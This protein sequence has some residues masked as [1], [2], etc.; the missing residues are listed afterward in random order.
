MIRWS[1]CSTRRDRPLVASCCRACVVVG[2][3]L[4]LGARLCSGMGWEQ[5]MLAGFASSLQMSVPS[6]L[7][8]T[9]LV[10]SVCSE[11]GGP[12]AADKHNM[13]FR[14]IV[15]HIHKRCAQVRVHCGKEAE[16]GR[17]HRGDEVRG[18]C[19]HVA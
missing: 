13:K 9:Q 3:R 7:I 17:L 1:V 15:F 2:H 16:E 10:L 14:E 4:M 19:H 12:T 5:D 18:R 6:V 8:L 11:A